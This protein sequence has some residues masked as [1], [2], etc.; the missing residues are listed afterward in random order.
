[1]ENKTFCDM[2]DEYKKNV[3]IKKIK[4][5]EAWIGYSIKIKIIDNN[6]II[7]KHTLITFCINEPNEKILEETVKDALFNYIYSRVKKQYTDNFV[8]KYNKKLQ[9][10]V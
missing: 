8:K 2:Q 4:I 9:E 1:M 10:E 6:R 7:K 5:V 3:K